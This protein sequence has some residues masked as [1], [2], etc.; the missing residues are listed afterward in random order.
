MFYVYLIRRYT[1]RSFYVGFTTDLKSR[2]LQHREKYPTELIYY[3]AYCEEKLARRREIKLK[4]YGSA[5][6]GLKK[7]LSLA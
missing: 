3:E 2:I 6:R 1:K 5:W 7:R 4:L